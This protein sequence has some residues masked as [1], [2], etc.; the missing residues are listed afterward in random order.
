[1]VR[2]EKTR[3]RPGSLLSSSRICA[4]DVFVS[5]RLLLLFLADSR[6]QPSSE[7]GASHC[8]RLLTNRQ[9]A[10]LTT[11]QSRPAVLCA[12]VS[13]S[14]S[15]T[16]MG[17]DERHPLLLLEARAPGMTRW[18]D[19]SGEDGHSV[20]SR[21][22]GAKIW[23][24]VT[25]G[26]RVGDMEHR[27]TASNVALCE[28]L[29]VACFRDRHELGTRWYHVP[30]VASSVGMEW[31][32]SLHGRNTRVEAPLGKDRI[33]ATL[34]LDAHPTSSSSAPPQLHRTASHSADRLTAPSIVARST[35]RPSLFHDTARSDQP[36]HCTARPTPAAASLFSCGGWRF[37]VRSTSVLG[38]LAAG[39]WSNLAWATSIDSAPVASRHAA[40]RGTGG[41]GGGGRRAQPIGH[42]GVHKRARATATIF[43]LA[44][45]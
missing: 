36:R 17:V 16:S 13:D 10:C 20:R 39:G 27:R 7:M 40:R 18:T 2:P 23:R 33:S 32:R 9:F 34:G 28:W 26:R 37:F 30:F 4:L 35:G 45:A 25:A 42:R 41:S 44:I 6:R 24:I 38:W 11:F 31:A 19:V 3:A 14:T 22:F 12:R 8:V 5:P 29:L 43:D 1:M 15:R 21:P